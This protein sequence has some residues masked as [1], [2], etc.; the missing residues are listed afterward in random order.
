MKFKGIFFTVI[1]A[2]LFGFT[3]VL[4]S[5]TYTMGSNAETLTFYRNFMV[6]PVLLIIMLVRK[7]SFKV[8]PRDLINILIIGALGRGITT[9]TLYASYDYVGIGTATTLHFLYPVFVALICRCF[10]GERLSKAKLTALITACA[11][12]MFF[13]D[14]NKSAA[15]AGVLLSVFSGLTYAFYIVGMD[16]KGLK[17]IDP[18]KVSFYMAIAVASSMFLY[19][20][21]VKRI[22]FAL[23][24]QAMLITFVIAI[25]T[26][27]L[28]VIFLQMGIKYLSATTASIF[29]LFEPVSSSISGALFLREDFTLFKV[30]GSI[31]IL[32]A[33][34]IMAICDKQPETEKA[35]LKAPSYH[36]DED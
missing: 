8:S 32:T 14:T 15:L 25:C 12:I 20:L 35:P 6:I 26:S 3:P 30:L 13:I 21:P 9:L 23:P 31:I 24:P 28:A 1:S 17:N 22:V 16:F 5:M 33:A 34:A 2:L 27:F 4:A 29:C 18:F 11:G 7:T 10:Y 36:N 19:N